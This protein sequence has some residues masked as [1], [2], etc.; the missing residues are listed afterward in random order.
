VFV[1]P[2]KRPI[3]IGQDVQFESARWSWRCPN[4][5]TRVAYMDEAM[6]A[7][8]PVPY[9]RRWPGCSSYRPRRN[10]AEAEPFRLSLALGQRSVPAVALRLWSYAMLPHIRATDR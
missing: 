2:A 10:K 9:R 3:Q 1:R 8:A 7:H 5:G 6:D 4:Y